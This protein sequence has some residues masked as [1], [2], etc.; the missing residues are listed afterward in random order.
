MP[1]ALPRLTWRGAA[2]SQAD[3]AVAMEVA[4][5]KVALLSIHATMK[6][7]QCMYQHENRGC[8]FCDLNGTCHAAL[9]HFAGHSHISCGLHSPMKLLV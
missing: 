5:R 4:Q 2:H 9:E 8:T 3:A 7:A 6:A 1:S